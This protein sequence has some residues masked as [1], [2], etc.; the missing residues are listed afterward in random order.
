MKLLLIEDTAAL[1]ALMRRSLTDAGFAVD[2]AETVGDAEL[3]I[4]VAPPD[5]IVST[6]GCPTAMA[7][8]SSGDCVATA[9]GSRSSW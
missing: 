2:V 3:L 1:A 4:D 7:A 8:T 9:V 5:V 6:S